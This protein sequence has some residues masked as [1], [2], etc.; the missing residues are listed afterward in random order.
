MD[1][2]RRQLRQAKQ[3]QRERDRAAGLVLYQT[4]L[5]ENLARR[6][7]AGLNIPG[8]RKMFK[9]FLQTEL[10]EIADFPQLHQLCWNLHTEFLTR[11][12]ALAIYERNWRLVDQQTL[13]PAEREF[14]AELIED[15]GDG[16]VNA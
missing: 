6:L 3:R 5:P 11:A 16:V 12:D 13:E 1:Q 2:R 10:V 8:F 9:V 4:K 7:K 14:I 15:L